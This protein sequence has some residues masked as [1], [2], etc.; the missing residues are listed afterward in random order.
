M[1]TFF[2]LKRLEAD[3]AL[4]EAEGILRSC[5]HCGFCLPTCPTYRLLGDERD[6]PRGRIYLIKQ[7][8]EKDRP[9]D[10]EVTTHLDRCLSCLGCMTACPSGVDYMH[11]ID[12]ARERVERTGSRS[13]GDRLLR[14]LL[15]IV[16]PRPVLFRAMLWAAQ[17]AKPFAR[18]LPGR[19]AS[20][21]RSSP[22]PAAAVQE[23][24]PDPMSPRRAVLL[25]GCVQPVLRPSINAAAARLLNREGWDL[26]PAPGEGCC[27]AI[28]H[29]L[30]KTGAAKRAAKANIRAWEKAAPEA[31]VV[32]ASGCG[33]MIKDYGHLLADEPAW[34]ARA[35]RIAG[36][37]KDLSEVLAGAAKGSVAAPLVVYQSPCSMQHG[38][39]ID[40]GPRALLVAAGFD[41]RE[42][43]DSHLCCGSAGT[44]SLLQPELAA[45]LGA[46]KAEALAASGAALVAT[47]NIGCLVQLTSQGR[48]PVLHLAELLDWAA[49]G[50]RPAGVPPAQVGDGS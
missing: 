18:W 26:A 6:S 15:A 2:D 36:L 33:T 32:T 25:G 38:Q 27:G 34:A 47:G 31:I 12:G 37:C 9:A 13:L 48:L 29:H 30:G 8:L 22:R 21:V 1:Q 41:L 16:L 7:M 10:A 28:A 24:K 45:R 42:A 40:A 35:K 19:L 46:N 44:Y 3:P 14:S 5:V 17:L 49:G 20:L 23:T 43:S 11:L 39:R 4:A 50:P